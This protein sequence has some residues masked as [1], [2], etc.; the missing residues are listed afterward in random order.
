MSKSQPKIIDY[1]CMH[2]MTRSYIMLRISYYFKL[3][4]YEA[5]E[6]SNLPLFTHL[7]FSFC[8]LSFLLYSPYFTF[9]LSVT[10]GAG[11]FDRVDF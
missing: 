11:K 10:C 4:L 3:T 6:G 2:K 7:L 8:F 5:S 1:A 9:P